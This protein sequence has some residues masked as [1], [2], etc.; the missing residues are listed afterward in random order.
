MPR[1]RTPFLIL[2]ETYLNKQSGA[3]E[4]LSKETRHFGV[5]THLLVLGQFRT[6]ILDVNKKKSELDAEQ[7]QECY[8][9]IKTDMAIRHA[10]TT[11]RQKG[12]PVA[13]ARKIVDLA[14]NVGGVLTGSSASLPL[15]I[16]I[17]SD[18]VKVMRSKCETTLASLDEWETFASSTDFEDVADIPSY[19]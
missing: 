5:N 18:A 15:R 1:D 3:V 16:P 4:C 14:K 17:G 8:A 10:A 6:N 7:G 13:A 9:A 12:D 19:F 11:G 2:D